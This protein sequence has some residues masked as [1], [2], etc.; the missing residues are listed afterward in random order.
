MLDNYKIGNHITLLRKEK[1]LTGEKL[2]ELLGVSGQAVSKWENGKNLPET[3][4]LPELSKILG[5][6]IDAL[7]MPQELIIL[8]ADYTDGETHIN[9]TQEVGKYINGNRLNITVNAQYIG[10]NIDSG[11][12][13]VLTVKYQ[14]PNG[15]N[16]AFAA[17]NNNLTINPESKGLET[18]IR[19]IF[20]LS[21][22][23]ISFGIISRITFAFCFT[24]SVR[25]CPIF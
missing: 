21:T 23:D 17:Q 22:A 12:V 2:A 16:Y 8:N 7:L 3:S 15:I 18:I 10:V 24:R 4:L 13:C 25:D 1:G 14:T 9:V 6:S 5:I 20:F 11:R 19:M